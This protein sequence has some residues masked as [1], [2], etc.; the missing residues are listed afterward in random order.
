MCYSISCSL[1]FWSSIQIV[2]IAEL[3][4]LTQMVGHLFSLK[5]FCLFNLKRA[6]SRML[7]GWWPFFF[8]FFAIHFCW[9]P[10]CERSEGDPL[11]LVKFM[12]AN[13]VSE[14]ENF[15][16][17]KSK[18]SH[19]PAAHRLMTIFFRLSTFA[20]EWWHLCERTEWESLKI[21]AFFSLFYVLFYASYAFFKLSKLL[22]GQNDM[23]APP[24]FRLGGRPPPLPPHFRRLW[25]WPLNL[26]VCSIQG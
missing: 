19:F 4:T 24:S 25:H 2:N 9:W 20:D 23:F 11:L 15:S 13:G 21:F 22:G 17:F 8:S 12:R 6:I 3:W 14:L 7:T 10:S 5:I 16:I 26:E 18:K 1:F